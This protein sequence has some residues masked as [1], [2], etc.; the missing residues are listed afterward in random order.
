MKDNYPGVASFKSYTCN[1]HVYETRMLPEQLVGDGAWVM[2]QMDR[3]LD[4]AD[5]CP[6]DPQLHGSVCPFDRRRFGVALPAGVFRPRLFQTPA[7]APPP[8]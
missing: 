1:G 7:D 5:V 2:K 6:S 3:N 8:R 4:H